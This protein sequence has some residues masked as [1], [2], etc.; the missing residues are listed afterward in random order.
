MRLIS[1]YRDFA[2]LLFVVGFSAA[3]ALAQAANF[4]P[5]AGFDAGSLT[6]ETIGSNKSLILGGAAAMAFIL[7]VAA[8]VRSLTRGSRRAVGG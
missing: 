6:T 3:Q 1:K 2:L 4:T 7:I 8:V 5:P